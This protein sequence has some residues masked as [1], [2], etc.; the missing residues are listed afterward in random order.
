M[1]GAQEQI[2]GIVRSVHREDGG[3]AEAKR[4]L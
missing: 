4:E 3:R 1:I 2:G